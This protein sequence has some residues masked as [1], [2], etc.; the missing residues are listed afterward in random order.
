VQAQV[1][2][3]LALPVR[4]SL[5]SLSHLFYK[6]HEDVSAPRSLPRESI[7]LYDMKHNV[8]FR[9]GSQAVA[10]KRWLGLTTQ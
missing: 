9:R 3:N 7:F 2:G 4:I 10:W 8:R 1:P 6:M 5:D